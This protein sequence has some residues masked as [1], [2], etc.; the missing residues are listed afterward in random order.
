MELVPA[1][2]QGGAALPHIAERKRFTLRTNFGQVED[3]QAK[4]SAANWWLNRSL[5]MLAC[6]IISAL[7]TPS[8]NL[9]SETYKVGSC[10]SA[11]K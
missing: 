8:I 11:L 6:V 9:D 3:V 10:A 5:A 7:V 4:W 1:Q 2:S